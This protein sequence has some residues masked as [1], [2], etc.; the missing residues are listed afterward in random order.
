M[1]AVV[2]QPADFL[3]VRLLLIG[4]N[5]GEQAYQK[6]I[7]WLKDHGE[8]LQDAS[9]SK[10]DE[11][12]ADSSSESEWKSPV[13]LID[14]TRLI[15]N[16]EKYFNYFENY[17]STADLRRPKKRAKVEYL[18]SVTIGYLNSRKVLEHYQLLV[19]F[20]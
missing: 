18:S 11:E 6:K 12:D 7:S 16:S 19:L 2:F 20:L 8:H 15:I 3:L 5:R 10:S 17:S 9:P 1:F 14:N 4:H 13:G